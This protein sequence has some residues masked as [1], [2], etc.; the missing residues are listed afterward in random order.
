MPAEPPSTVALI[1]A[2]GRGERAGGNIPK[3]YRRIAGRS[4][5]AHAID[6]L[7]AH[8]G[9]DAVRVVIGAGQQ[10][11][12]QAAIG[13]R[14]LGPPI[15]GG[16][17][18]GRSRVPHQ[19]EDVAVGHLGERASADAGPFERGGELGAQG[20]A[21]IEVQLLLRYLRAIGELQE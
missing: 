7:A 12:Y 16:A 18:A 8:P 19:R 10:S 11:L 6:A 2:A 3:Q 4:V 21:P 13:A 5:L 9:I 15:E 14:R 1:V 20:L 17:S